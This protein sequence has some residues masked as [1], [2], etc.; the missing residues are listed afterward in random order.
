MMNKSITL[1][2]NELQLRTTLMMSCKNLNGGFLNSFS[3]NAGFLTNFPRE[4]C[5]F[6][7]TVGFISDILQKN[8][9]LLFSF[10]LEHQTISTNFRKNLII[11]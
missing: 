4:S 10:S 3:V 2:W 11:L 5:V 7:I 9:L 8:E 6:F 1:K